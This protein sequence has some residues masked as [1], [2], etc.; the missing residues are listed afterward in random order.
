MSA[1]YFKVGQTI[2]LNNGL[3]GVIRFVGQT[4]F[5]PGIDWI[6]VELPTAN[7]KNNGTV[8]G[9]HY[10]DCDDEHGMFVQPS[11]IGAIIKDAPAPAP[12]PTPA[13]ASA[14]AKP[15]P[16]AATRTGRPSVGPSRPSSINADPTAARRRSL[17]APSPSPVRSRPSSI[18]RSPTRAERPNLTTT[19]STTANSRTGTPSAAPARK[20]SSASRPPVG[21]A[22]SSMGPPNAPDPSKRRPSNAA[23]AAAT[24]ATRPTTSRPVSGRTSLAPASRGGFNRPANGRVRSTDSSGND[25]PANRSALVSPNKSD[26]DVSPVAARTRALNRLT[27][28]G[29]GSATATPSSRTKSTTTARPS[30]AANS[31]ALRENED[32]KTKLRIL[33]SKRL[34]DKEQL[35]QLEK[36]QQQISRYQSV[37]KTVEEKYKKATQDAANAQKNLEDA[38]ERLAKVDD[39]E[40]E[41]ETTMELLL[42]DKEV[43]EEESEHYKLEL[44]SLKARVDE[45]QLENEVLKLENTEF[46]QNVTAEERTSDNWI[47]LQKKNELY[48]QAIVTIHEKLEEVNEKTSEQIKGLKQDL[49]EYDNVKQEFQIA[50]EKLVDAETRTEHLKAQL[51]N[52]LGSEEII[53]KL[54]EDN[55]AQSDTIA[56]LRE[57]I[58]DLEELKEISDELEVNHLEHEK[59]LEKIIESKDS[60]IFRLSQQLTDQNRDIDDMEYTIG[61][62]KE[63]VSN[64]QKDLEDM[65]ASNAMNEAESEQ[66]NSKSR[67]LLDLNQ[68]L[69]IN[70]AKTQAKTIELELERMHATEAK[71]HLEIVTLFLPESYEQDKNSVQALLKFM[72]MGVKTD[73]LATFVKERI[74]GKGHPG[75]EDDIFTGCNAINKL[76]W[77]SSM[78]KRFVNHINHCSLEEFAAYEGATWELAPV[79]SKLNAWIDNLQRGGGELQLKDYAEVLSRS[80]K[81][82]EHLAEQHISD[83]PAAVADKMQMQTVLMQGHLESAATTFVAMKEM[84]Q[85]AIPL[86][87]DI[88]IDEPWQSFDANV[89]HVINQTRSAKVIVSKA[90]RSLEDLQKRSLVLNPDEAGTF[91]ESADTAQRLAEMAQAVALAVYT[92]TSNEDR[93][94]PLRYS[95]VSKAIHQIVRDEFQ[96]DETTLLSNYRSRA[97]ALTTQVAEL[98]ALCAD[99]SQTQ[100][101]DGSEAPW[102][103]RAQEI[104]KLKIKPVDIEEELQK[105][106]DHYNEAR[107]AIAVRDESLST[108]ALRIETLEARYRD[109]Q[110]KASRITEMEAQVLAAQDNMAKLKDDIEKQDRELK[111]LESDRDS[112][113]KKA[114]DSRVINTDATTKAGREQAV[115]TQREMDALRDDISSLQA[116]VRYLREDNRRARTTEQAAYDWLTEPLRKPTPVA[117]Q[118]R[119]LV[120]TEGKDV[121]GELL[122]LAGSAKAYNL[123]TL[124]EDKLAWRPYRLTPQS[125]ANMQAENY[126]SWQSWRSSVLSDAKIVAGAHAGRRE[127]SEK[128]E[129]MRKQAARLRIQLPDENGKVVP[130]RGDVQIV[131]SKEWEGLQGRLGVV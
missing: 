94:E 70:A 123:K 16:A 7:G 127:G 76:T 116:A 131:G 5:R 103:L 71:L 106:K 129:I 60:N 22:R 34:E 49:E 63:L 86:D 15:K 3:Q 110:A 67:E 35:K 19:A 79:D 65:Q 61:R 95:D 53:E 98:A 32:L 97:K 26:D 124:P 36:L 122:K 128:R 31:T 4:T 119:N 104:R 77:V 96:A 99:I 47:A 55:A 42:L 39:M 18:A 46:E 108:S 117:E 78:C 114:G 28:G 82:L 120:A 121:L 74:G 59:E 43:A 72:Q 52:A 84:V 25:S 57:N 40:A 45:L 100:E 2:E 48:Y 54:S 80:I 81:L 90:L 50:K 109:S 10:F 66:I 105:A 58:R 92:L 30:P 12:A 130:G 17:N 115:A 93:A 44:D 38:Q 87:A 41:H 75:H 24:S 62:F 69:Q 107:L 91:E 85:K 9:V 125:H 27:S 73:L 113:K 20:L 111:T 37:N 23:S 112:W 29:S 1:K 33:E 6:G 56:T 11:A 13:S 118:R 64:L 83:N 89:D 8:A 51:D 88:E 101:Y 126:A 14:S 68:K 21:A 102:K